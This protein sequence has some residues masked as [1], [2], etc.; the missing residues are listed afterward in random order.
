M[1]CEN[2][3]KGHD[4]TYGSGRFC[5][6][7]CARGF[8]TKTKRKSINAKTSKAL[9]GRNTRKES[10]GKEKPHICEWCG[11]GY[12]KGSSLGGHI[13]R[14]DKNPDAVTREKLRE[15]KLLE[16]LSL[17]WES[18][19]NMGL[20]RLKI[21]REQDGKC[22][23]CGIGDWLGETLVLELEHIDGDN[24]NNSRDNLEFLCPNC[25]SQT[26]TW[27]GRNKNKGKSGKRVSDND[28][29]EALERELSIR[30][31]LLSVGIAAKGGNY[32]RAYRLLAT[33]HSFRW[34]TG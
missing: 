1:N 34:H 8:S 17:P 23:R 25:H 10:Q 15:Q 24:K 6:I 9:K 16:Q 18:I 30:Q 7:K 19:P 26:K 5:S 4:G 3:N 2:C 22:N 21:H 28:L 31:A 12:A 20:K 29:L 13:V 11:K 14:C 32:E 27:R 33:K